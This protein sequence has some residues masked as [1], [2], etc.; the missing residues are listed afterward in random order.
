MEQLFKNEIFIIG[1]K[2]FLAVFI[3]GIIG[4]ERG[5]HGR[6]AG[7]RTHILVC[8]GSTL[9]AMTGLYIQQTVGTGDVMRIAAQVVSGVGFLGAG[10]IIH[11]NGNMITGL[12]T[13][14][15]VWSVATIGIAIGYGYYIAALIASAAFMLAVMV[16]AKFESRKRKIGVV[17]AELDDMKK[18][19]ETIS[20][21]PDYVPYKHHV[22][23]VPPKSA[24]AGNIGLNIVMEKACEFDI[25]KILELENVIYV[26]EE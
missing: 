11:R 15:G 14:A 7:M 16:F 3:S 6:S 1:F 12:T 25:E 22:D 24:R 9:T 20:K 2:I 23:V 19:N 17:Y 5:R 4:A 8:L 21:L 10:M 18:V 13:A 26:V